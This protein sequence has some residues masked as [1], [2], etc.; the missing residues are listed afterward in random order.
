VIATDDRGCI[1]GFNPAAEQ[2]TGWRSEEA[3]GRHVDEVLVL[4]N[5]QTRQ[6][7]SNPVE[8]V[9]REG[10]VSG[11]A[12]HTVLLTRDKREVPI[13][14][15]AAPVRGDGGRLL[16]AVMVFRDITE[17]RQMERERAARDRIARELA[18]IVQSSDDAIVGMDLNGVI[19]A[20]KRIGRTHVRI[21]SA[22]SHRPV[23]PADRSGGTGGRRGSDPGADSPRGAPRSLRNRAAPKRWRRRRGVAHRLSDS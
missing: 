15:S 21:C 4:V 8:R 1:T 5:E 23:D 12:N 22:G 9:L 7:T 2:L 11:L 20:W 17:R 13:D 18:A 16:G 3:I 6:P 19:T 14:D 10:A